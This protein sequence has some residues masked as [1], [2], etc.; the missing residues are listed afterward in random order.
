MEEAL[1]FSVPDE[2][3]SKYRCDEFVEVGAY[4]PANNESFL[5]LDNLEGK[6][7]TLALSSAMLHATR[8]SHRILDAHGQNTTMEST[9]QQ[10]EETWYPVCRHLFCDHT[11][12]GAQRHHT[13]MF[14]A[15]QL[16]IWI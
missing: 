2:L 16:K 15:L 10:L 8:V 13:S 11:K 5:Q 4:E 6:A 1:D 9:L 7:K 12:L 14:G 3:L